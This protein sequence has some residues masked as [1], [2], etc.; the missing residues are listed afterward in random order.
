MDCEVPAIK[1]PPRSLGIREF[2]NGLRIKTSSRLLIQDTGGDIWK[3]SIGLLAYLKAEIG[4]A[5]LKRMKILEISSGTGALGLCLSL[6]GARIMMTD[7]PSM[8][9]LI[10]ENTELNKTLLKNCR[11][12]VHPLDW[13]DSSLPNAVQEYGPYDIVIASDGATRQHDLI[14]PLFVG[15]QWR[16][17]QCS[18]TTT[19]SSRSSPRSAWSPSRPRRP[20]KPRRCLSRRRSG[21]SPSSGASARSPRRTST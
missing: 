1:L 10:E 12:E 20:R 8:T 7:L 18:T 19:W 16:V 15:S 11:F 14:L 6:L 2:S 13:R 21:V 4:D 3:G 5:G 17:R 9:A